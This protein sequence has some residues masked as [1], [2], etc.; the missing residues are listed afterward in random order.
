MSIAT[1]VVVLTPT[2]VASSVARV[3]S[4]VGRRND[5]GLAMGGSGAQ[6]CTL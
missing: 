5:V 3:S 4:S 6:M 2:R 1:S